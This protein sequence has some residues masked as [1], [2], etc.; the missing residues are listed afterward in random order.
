MKWLLVIP[1]VFFAD[2]TAKKDFKEVKEII[3]RQAQ[4]QKMM[5]QMD[6]MT[7][8]LDSIL[9]ELPDTVR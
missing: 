5:D 6:D 4:T 2:T 3:I 7:L 1:F 8:K 9:K